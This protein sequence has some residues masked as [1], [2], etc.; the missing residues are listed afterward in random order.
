MGLKFSQWEKYE[1]CTIHIYREMCGIPGVA[2]YCETHEI[3][4]ELESLK[5]SVQKE[6]EEILRNI[7]ST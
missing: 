3:Y 4:H 2:Q 1:N 5:K 7:L 6:E